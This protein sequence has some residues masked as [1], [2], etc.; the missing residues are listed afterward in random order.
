MEM[1]IVLAVAV[2]MMAMFVWHKVPFG[3][4]TMTCCIILTLTG[5]IDVETAFSGFGNKIVVLV[6]PM[7]ALGAVLGKTS[8]VGKIRGVMETMKGKRG[9]LMVLTLFFFTALL[10]QFIPSTAVMAIMVVFAAQIGDNGDITPTRVILPMLGVASCFKFRFPVS[11][12]AANFATINALYE[13]II[14]DQAYHLTMLE[15]FIFCIIPMVMVGIFCIFGWKLMP[16]SEG[17]LNQDAVNAKT[18]ESVMTPGQEKVVYIVFILA[19]VIMITNVGGM[20]YLAPAIAVALLIWTG[21]LDAKEASKL[22]TSDTIWM[23]VGVLVVSDALGSS[24]ASEAIGN[25]LLNAVGENPNSF[26]IML[27]FAAVTVIMTNFL[28][29]AA[30]Q[31]VIVPLAASLALAGGWDP[32]GLVLI[33]GIANMA[34]V[35]LPSGSGEAAVA[36]AA[37]GYNPAKVLRFTLPYMAV[38]ILGYAISAQLLYPLYG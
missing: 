37:G 20:L 32:R 10:A 2:F 25:L 28:S 31:T 24:G 29:N 8:M 13:G 22:M 15:P 27:L 4:T 7:L 30:T 35:A 19:M 9:Y 26:M 36:F 33:A 11:A 17:S 18:Q 1:Y 21:I 6:A 12:G 16:K 5:V 38:S 14:T 3:L 34:D 23:M